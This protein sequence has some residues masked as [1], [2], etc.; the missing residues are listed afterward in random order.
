MGMLAKLRPSAGQAI[1]ASLA[2]LLVPGSP[3]QASETS[4]GDRWRDSVVFTAQAQL[5]PRSPVPATGPSTAGIVSETTVRRRNI[6]IIGGAGL[7]LYV[8]G[9]THWWEEGFTRKFQTVNE[10]WFGENTYAGGADKLGHAYGTY[11]GTRLLART[12][13][14]AGN[15][16]ARALKLAAWSVLG[17]YTAVEVLDGFTNRWRFSKEDAVMNA[18]GAGLAVV[19]ES[20]PALDRV[21]DFRLLYRPSD[22]P[23]ASR[24][25]DP[26]GDYSGQIYLVVAKASG[27]AAF[28]SH[29]LLR[30][31]EL[32]AGYGV[33]GYHESQEVQPDRSRNL[34]VGL[35]LNLSELLGRTAYRDA[36]PSNWQWRATRG[37]LEVVQVPGTAALAKHRVGGP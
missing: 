8:Y 4:G 15:D 30:Y 26:F 32:A 37:F 24:R 13:E 23:A 1:V 34:Y 28:R 25:F 33:K 31:V 7:G 27:V 36:E 17:A 12:F 6:A 35:S 16:D 18:V 22:D 11:V 21:L 9:R 5:P 19:T 10:G 14:W 20:N 2:C 3:G 29:P